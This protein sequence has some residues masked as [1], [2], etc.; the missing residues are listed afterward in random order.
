MLLFNITFSIW[1]YYFNTLLY[2]GKSRKQLYISHLT[3]K[4]AKLTL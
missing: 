3:I 2:D 1:L 4:K